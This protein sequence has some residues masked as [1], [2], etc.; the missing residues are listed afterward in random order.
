MRFGKYT[1]DFYII[2]SIL[3]HSGDG[4]YSSVE[5]CWLCWYIVV[6]SWNRRADNG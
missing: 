4:I 6:V 2:P 5:I 1:R 3:V